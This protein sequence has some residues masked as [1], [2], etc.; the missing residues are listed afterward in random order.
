M[1]QLRKNLLGDKPYAHALLAFLPPSHPDSSKGAIGL[2]LYFF[3]FSTWTGKPGLYVSSSF[4]NMCL[5]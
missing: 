5:C 1:R 4:I 3:N 2:A